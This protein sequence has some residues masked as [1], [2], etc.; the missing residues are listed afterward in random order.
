MSGPNTIPLSTHLPVITTSAPRSRALL[1]GLAL[2]VKSNMYSY[3]LTHH[4]KQNKN[5]LMSLHEISFVH[6]ATKWLLVFL[7]ASIKHPVNFM[8]TE[9]LV[10]TFIQNILKHNVSCFWITFTM[11]NRKYKVFLRENNNY[12]YFI[13]R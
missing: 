7:K 8:T 10:L 6:T 9:R 4:H 3:F 5:H 13:C 1:T 2:Q 12:S 11:S